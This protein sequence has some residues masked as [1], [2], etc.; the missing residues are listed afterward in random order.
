M[1]LIRFEL[2]D[3]ASH[4][5]LLRFRP[6][7]DLDPYP[8]YVQMDPYGCVT[9]GIADEGTP[10]QEDDGCVLLRW[11]IPGNVD[12]LWLSR[13]LRDAST[14]S[15]LERIHGGHS[16]GGHGARLTQEAKSLCAGLLEMLRAGAS[17][18]YVTVYRDLHSF[19]FI[20]GLRW[21]EYWPSGSLDEGA[22]AIRHFI[23]AVDMDY[24]TLIVTGDDLE[25]IGQYLLKRA[26]DLLESQQQGLGE[27]HLRELVFCKY[28]T[29]EQA[30]AYRRAHDLG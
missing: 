26:Y 15:L 21:L 13:Y 12:A 8:A 19:I 16:I 4:S 30:D 10:T 9:A 18:N 2:G 29:L 14:L 11:H 25:S 28:A 6:G 3:L 24:P 7:S 5:A 1:S 20:S 22:L 27:D 23:E 17:Q